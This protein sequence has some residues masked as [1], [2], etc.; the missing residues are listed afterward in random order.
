MGFLAN[1]LATPV[2]GAI[3]SPI[4]NGLLSAQKQKLDA[5]GSHEARTVEIAQK[6]IELDRREAEINAQVVIAEQGHWSTRWVR[7]IWAAPFVFF[8]WKI[9]VWDKMLG[10]GVTDALD[11]K[12]WNVFMAMVIAYFGGRSAE[13]VATTIAGAFMKKP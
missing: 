6:A 2:I 10:W 11:P 9:V 4:I 1:L 13:K 5:V 3:L 8:T 7:P 12:M